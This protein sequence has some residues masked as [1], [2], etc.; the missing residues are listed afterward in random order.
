MKDWRPHLD[1]AR[2]SAAL[3]EEILAARD[4]EVRAASAR[5]GHSAIAAAEEVREL[6]AGAS[7]E[8]TER[9]PIAAASLVVLARQH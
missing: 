9:L 2:L 1:L 3:A 6:I 5:S 8:P 7:G 4:D